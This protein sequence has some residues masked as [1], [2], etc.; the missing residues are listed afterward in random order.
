M[1]KSVKTRLAH[2]GIIK[3]ENIM[4]NSPRFTITHI[5]LAGG[6]INIVKPVILAAEDLEG[7][8]GHCSQMSDVE[9]FALDKLT[10]PTQ[11][12]D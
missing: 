3:L 4:S 6:K 8:R 1:L 12:L 11:P 2:F 7:G 5:S 10:I 9:Y